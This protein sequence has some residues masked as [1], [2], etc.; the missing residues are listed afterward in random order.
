VQLVIWL[1]LFSV[2]IRI[3][4]FLEHTQRVA[5]VLNLVHILGFPG[6][7]LFKMDTLQQA[8]FAGPYE[9]LTTPASRRKG[10]P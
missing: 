7:V 8:K 4:C 5:Q 6:V 9:G 1:G 2:I 3:V 10:S